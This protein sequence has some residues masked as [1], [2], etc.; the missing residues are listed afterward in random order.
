MTLQEIIEIVGRVTYKPGWTILMGLDGERPYIQV[1]VSEVS[2][3]SIDSY[4]R[5]GTRTPWK[6]GKRY[7][8]LHMCKQEVVGV[9]FDLIKAAEMHEVHEWFRYRG[10]SI[11]NPHLDPDV[12]VGV[13]RKKSS[14]VTRENAMTMVEGLTTPQAD[15]KAWFNGGVNADHAMARNTT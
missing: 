13:A 4:L 9:I 14:F 11:Y 5:D 6:S 8:S 2:D 15:L 1:E 10:A 7:L 12:L 3:A